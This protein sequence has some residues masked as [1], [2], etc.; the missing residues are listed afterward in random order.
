MIIS[1]FGPDGVG[2]SVVASAL[3]KRGIYVISGTG[4][5]SWPDKTWHNELT[6]QGLHEPSIDDSQ[7]F[8]TKIKKLHVLARTLE[9]QYGSVA[10]D[11]DPFHKTWMHDIKRGNDREATLWR[12]AGYGPNDKRL[13]VYLRLSDSLD[14]HEQAIEIQRRIQKRGALAHFDPKSVLQ[15]Q[16][17]IHAYDAIAGQLTARNERVVTVYTDRPLD[18][19]SFMKM[20]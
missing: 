2:K 6:A 18:V 19:D 11:S 3:Q 4:V 5:A 20:V 16:K 17:M 15:S 10:I 13:H 1:L 14:E 7:H 12:Q 9:D 8:L